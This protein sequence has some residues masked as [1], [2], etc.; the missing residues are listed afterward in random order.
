VASGDSIDVRG[1][2]A[3]AGYTGSDPV[4]DGYLK[5]V[6]G[7]LQAN[8]HQPGN[9][10]WWVVATGVVAPTPIV[11]DNGVI[12]G[13]YAHVGGTYTMDGTSHASTDGY[14]TIVLTGSN[15]SN[16]PASDGGITVVDQGS[17][18]QLFGHRGNDT[19]ILSPT[20][21][22]VSDGWGGIDT[23]VLNAHPTVN[24]QDTTY[25]LSPGDRI[26]LHQLLQGMG[27][28]GSDPI[29]DGYVKV[30]SDPRAFGQMG[31]NPIHIE[32]DPDGPGGSAPWTSALTLNGFTTP[33]HYS[34]GFLLV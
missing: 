14:D 31:P 17:N 28:T 8:Y 25:A 29:A 33:L 26:D 9:D 4:A 12:H 27:Y 10:G 13:A 21:K 15:Q 3:K 1:L 16:G 32:F 34:D 23:I 6:N 7:Q 18:N 5:I 24:T 20:T 2:L 19:F 22:S 30:D 11:Y